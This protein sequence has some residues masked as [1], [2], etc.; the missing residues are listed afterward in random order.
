MGTELFITE[1]FK[2]ASGG[3][4]GVSDRLAAA[5]WY[6]NEAIVFANIGWSGINTHNA[7]Q[8]IS[9]PNDPYDPVVQQVDGNFGPGPIFYGMYLFSKI[10]GQQT[11]AVAVGGNANVN[12]IA[13]KGGNGNANILV[14]NNDA[15]GPVAVTPAQ[16]SAWTTANVLKLSTSDGANCTSANPTVGGQPIGEG[17]TWTGAPY[18]IANGASVTLNPCEAA[19]IQIQP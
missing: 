11:A 18:S 5:A 1:S 15:N 7:N 3:L 10:E 13:T 19:L 2:G 4:V 6:V 17:G 9:I 8:S 16:S 14:V 12:A